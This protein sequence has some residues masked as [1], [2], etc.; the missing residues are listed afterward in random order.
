VVKPNG[1]AQLFLGAVD[2]ADLQSV[3][4]EAAAG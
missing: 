4:A 3:L 1:D 2:D